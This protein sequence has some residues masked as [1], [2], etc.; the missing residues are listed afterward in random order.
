M[1]D[2]EHQDLARSI[3]ASIRAARREAQ[4]TL[5]QLAKEA[6][7]SQP[8][9]SQAENGKLMP[10]VINLHRI[11]Q[12]LNTTAHEILE[13]G[14]RPAVRVV[15]ATEGRSYPLGP[16]ATVRFCV[17]RNRLMDCNEVMAGPHSAAESATTHQGEEFVYV[18]DG[19]IRMV[20]GESEHLLGAGDTVYY[21]ATVPH[22]WF[23]D[24]DTP[25]RFLFTSS[26]PGF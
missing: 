26:P 18:I 24:S 25:A 13:R 11:A 14:A 12:A 10:S 5:T 21:A 22:Q 9:L 7:V 8:F 16:D 19:S 20:I 2:E 1:E 17:G 15:R 4:L 3:G 23:N 6:G